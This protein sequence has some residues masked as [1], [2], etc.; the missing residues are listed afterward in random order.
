MAFFESPC[1]ASEIDSM[2]VEDLEGVVYVVVPMPF[3]EHP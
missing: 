2:V 1:Y 3:W